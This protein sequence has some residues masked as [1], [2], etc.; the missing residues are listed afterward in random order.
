MCVCAR[1]CVCARVRVCVCVCVCVCECARTCVCAYMCLYVYKGVC[2]HVC[3]YVCVY[4]WA[5]AR[6]CVCVCTCA[7]ARVLL[8]GFLPVIF[9]VSFDVLG[10]TSMACAATRRPPNEQENRG[11]SPPRPM[12][13]TSDLQ[14]ATL[15]DTLPEA[16]RAKTSWPGVSIPLLDEKASL[17]YN[18]CSVAARKT[19]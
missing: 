8:T 18:Y 16:W 7:C 12:S 11:R 17:I 19:V 2:V 13:L 4:V 15:M 9:I 14:S 6:A 1:A 10:S 3:L 5:R